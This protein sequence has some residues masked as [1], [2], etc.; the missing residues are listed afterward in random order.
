MREHANRQIEST[1][2]VTSLARLALAFAV[3]ELFFFL[4]ERYSQVLKSTVRAYMCV[5]VCVC[6]CDTTGAAPVA[7][8]PYGGLEG[9]QALSLALY[10][11]MKAPLLKEGILYQLSCT[12]PDVPTRRREGTV[13]PRVGS[14]HVGESLVYF[15]FFFKQCRMHVVYVH[16][17]VHDIYFYE[18]DE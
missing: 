3:R 18:T 12:S 10:A 17:Y 5:Y 14:G 6:L 16:V 15:S 2:S 13:K 8:G 7:V 1:T 9:R 4:R 11:R